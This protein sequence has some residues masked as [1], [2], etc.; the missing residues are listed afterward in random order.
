MLQSSC[1]YLGILHI[2][3]QRMRKSALVGPLGM[4]RIS[5]YD[6]PIPSEIVPGKQG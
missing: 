6:L 3:I 4:L 2:A 1:P 5:L